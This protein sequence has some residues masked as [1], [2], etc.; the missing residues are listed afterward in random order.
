MTMLDDYQSK[1]S[2]LVADPNYNSAKKPQDPCLPPLTSD[3]SIRQFI[4]R[5]NKAKLIKQAKDE[6]L[7]RNDGSGWKNEVTKPCPPKITDIII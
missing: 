4:E 5:Q 6:Y 2:H 3:R 7:K 1:T